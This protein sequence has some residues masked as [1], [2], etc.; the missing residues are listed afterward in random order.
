MAH[1]V[2][3]QFLLAGVKMKKISVIVPVYKTEEY[4][5]RCVDSILASTYGNLEVILV[6][7]GS[8]D[9]A[10]R[11]CD[12][13]AEKDARVMVIHKENGGLSS[14]RNAGLDIATGDYITFVDSD[15]YIASDIYEKLAEHLESAADFAMMK[16]CSADDGGARTESIKEF[17][18]EFLGVHTGSWL[19]TKICERRLDTSVCFCIFKRAL[20]NS[21]RFD[22]KRLNEDFLLMSELLIMNELNV[23]IS[24][25]VGYYYYTREGSI[26]KSG[27]GKSLHDAVYNTQH[28]KTMAEERCVDL[29]PYIGAYAAYQARTALLLMTKKQYRENGEFVKYCR[30]V[31]NENKKYIKGS[32]MNK[33]ERLFCLMYI[34]MPRLT[35]WFFDLVRRGRS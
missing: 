26:T 15:D 30:E 7:D 8:P 10:G 25:E 22:E 33:K 31:I 6:D 18:T 17:P 13:Y 35:K 12:E 32:F 4:L 27:F 2:K 5:N 21:V 9:N 19:L 28:A 1:D 24:D 29:V 23:Y 34:K 16:M 14:A 20:F 3:H 11:I